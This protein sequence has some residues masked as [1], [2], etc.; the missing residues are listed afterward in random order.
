[1]SKWGKETQLKIDECVLNIC[2]LIDE[3]VYKNSS[4]RI[5]QQIKD[6]IDKFADWLH[7]K[8]CNDMIDPD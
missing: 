2:N 8:T 5:H 6:N 4:F 1:M 3:N 7:N